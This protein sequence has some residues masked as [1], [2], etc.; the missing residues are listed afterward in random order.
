MERLRPR[1]QYAVVTAISR[2][3]NKCT[4]IFNGDTNAVDVN[5]G[6]IQPL[7]VGQTVR[8]EGYRGD[9]FVA[10]IV[11]FDYSYKSTAGFARRSGWLEFGA[12]DLT[13]PWYE[14]GALWSPPKVRKN[15][16]GRVTV[17]GLM[18]GSSTSVAPLTLPSDM[19]AG[20]GLKEMFTT[21]AN[22]DLSR[23][24]VDM[25]TGVITVPTLTGGAASFCSL[26]GISF[27]SSDVDES[28]WVNI[29]AVGAPAFQ[30]S[31]TN[32]GTNVWVG[33][34]YYKDAWG[35]VH[36][37]GLIKS[38]TSAAAAFTLPAGYRPPS[39]GGHLIFVTA[40][41]GTKIGARVD[42]YTDGSVA[43][44]LLTNGSNSWVSLSGVSFYA[45]GVTGANDSRHDMS[46][47][48]AFAN[49]WLNFGSGYDNAKYRVDPDG[50]VSLTGLI[51]S[52]TAA[53]ILSNNLSTQGIQPPASHLFPA[54]A[55][56]GTAR[57]DVTNAGVLNVN[58]YF[59]GGTNG[60]V[61]L[62]NIRYYPI[63]R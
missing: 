33:A 28:Q 48:F 1:Y 3:T 54:V 18:N 32:Y 16:N 34:G 60:Y 22:G 15:P 20:H 23:V 14:Y 17:S 61:S 41:N 51:K 7:K 25:A 59:N 8:V 26:D 40:G 6:F 10:D 5:M 45:G 12:N 29:G 49:G 36:L 44:V 58:S 46:S 37:R 4:V 39:T 13:S 11:G 52:G 47:F 30:N 2:S 31:W 35:W 62:S 9:R 42:V 19:R 27:V 57:L 55:N 24:D 50:M 56:T 43:P 53:T 63:G 21:G 38:G